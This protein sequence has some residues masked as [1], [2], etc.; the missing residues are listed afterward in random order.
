[1]RASQFW[2]S[3]PKNLEAAVQRLYLTGAGDCGGSD[4]PSSAPMEEIEARLTAER[5]LERKF[6][7]LWKR[8]PEAARAIDWQHAFGE[9]TAP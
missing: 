9:A 7:V 8:D 6:R 4:W 1:M 2:R 5:T 3:R